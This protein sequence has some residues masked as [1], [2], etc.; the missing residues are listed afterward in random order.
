MQLST[1]GTGKPGFWFDS[2]IN[3]R[4]WISSAVVVYMLTQVSDSS[5]ILIMV[6]VKHLKGLKI[7]LNREDPAIV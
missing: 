5:H 6:I 1:G 2:A 7:S 3:P 4:E